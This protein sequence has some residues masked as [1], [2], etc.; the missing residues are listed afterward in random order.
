MQR[1][2]PFPSGIRLPVFFCPFI[3]QPPLVAHNSHRP[4]PAL[5]QTAAFRQAAKLLATDGNACRT[6][7]TPYS[8]GQR[9]VHRLGAA[10]VG[11]ACPWGRETTVTAKEIENQRLSARSAEVGITKKLGLTFHA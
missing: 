5:N 10:E 6:C 7:M 9:R 3:Y 11:P 4:R 8:P 2:G 1:I